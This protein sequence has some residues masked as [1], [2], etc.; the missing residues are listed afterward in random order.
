MNEKIREIMINSGYHAFLKE[1]ERK[2][3]K[4]KD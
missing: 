4:A 3:E 2:N 1:N